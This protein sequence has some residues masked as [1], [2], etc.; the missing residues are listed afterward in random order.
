M[1]AIKIVTQSKPEGVIRTSEQLALSGIAIAGVDGKMRMRCPCCDKKI[2]VMPVGT[3]WA[4]D[5]DDLAWLEEQP[6]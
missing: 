3:D 6:K 1:I 2:V 5:T 4:P